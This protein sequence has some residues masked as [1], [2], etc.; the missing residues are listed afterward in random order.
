MKPERLLNKL[1]ED[2][3]R[4]Y[5]ADDLST[6]EQDFYGNVSN[7]YNTFRKD[8]QEY[9][10]KESDTEKQREFVIS[11]KSF[12]NNSI[13]PL[14]EL[15]ELPAVKLNKVISRSIPGKRTIIDFLIRDE[16]KVVNHKT[17]DFFCIVLGHENWESFTKK[18]NQRKPDDLNPGTN[19]EFLADIKHIKNETDGENLTGILK[20]LEKLENN[21]KID[22]LEQDLLK[23]H[24]LKIAGKDLSLAN[25]ILGFVEHPHTLQIADSITNIDKVDGSQLLINHPEMI[26]NKSIININTV[27]GGLTIKFPFDQKLK[28]LSKILRYPYFT[29]RETEMLKIDSALKNEDVLVIHGEHGVGKSALVTEYII[30]YENVF[31][32]ILWINFQQSIQYSFVNNELFRIAKNEEGLNFESYYDAIINLLLNLPGKNK[33]L[34]IDNLDDVEILE[35]CFKEREV[36]L[37]GWKIIFTTI[38]NPGPY[39]NKIPVEDLPFR[40]SLELFNKISAETNQSL[41]LDILG[42]HGSYSPY[43]VEFFAHAVKQLKQK[44]T[45]LKLKPDFSGA[46]HEKVTLHYSKHNKGATYDE[47]L[48]SIFRNEILLKYDTINFLLLYAY[49]PSNLKNIGLIKKCFRNIYPQKILNELIL[50]YCKKGW[51]SENLEMHFLRQD[52]LLKNIPHSFDDVKKLYENIEHFLYVNETDNPIDK[53]AFLPIAHSMI[54]KAGDKFKNDIVFSLFHKT[55]IIEFDLGNFDKALA[56]QKK[57]LATNN[58]LLLKEIYFDTGLIYERLSKYDNA[59][60]DLLKSN[61]IE[62]KDILRKITCLAKINVVY[63]KLYDNTRKPIHLKGALEYALQTLNMI[64][65]LPDKEKSSTVVGTAYIDLAVTFSRANEHDKVALYFDK[66]IEIF[67]KRLGTLNH[68]W[69]A[70][71]YNLYANSLRDNNKILEAFELY[72]IALKIRENLYK[73]LPKHYSLAE[74]YNDIAQAHYD[75]S[76]VEKAKYYIN[77]ALEIRRVIFKPDHIRLIESEK[78]NK[79]I[80]T[81]KK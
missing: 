15:D 35:R 4:K 60:K 6:I 62:S 57:A 2:I 32:K 80:Q 9:C 3:L 7:L 38:C 74:S 58:T 37:K 26:T 45:F 81:Y 67:R 47:A 10:L 63:R 13:K 30:K 76:D 36:F 55:G 27:N 21:L 79:L 16:I 5:N 72:E 18:P 24:A 53:F 49:L 59:L 43:Y 48:A 64:D 51:L 23:K 75:N 52:Y 19:K 46:K 78:L 77:K 40:I 8:Y 22:I 12:Y 1:K 20:I 11:T 39:N 29:G 33:L 17:R 69:I 70:T 65:N 31:E 28:Y 61:E 71:S 68:P 34:V 25:K 42:K 56:L 73:R 14:F 50:E 41:F 54:D 66:G 44:N